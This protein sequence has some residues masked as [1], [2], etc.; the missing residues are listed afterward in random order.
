M[1]TNKYFVLFGVILTFAISFPLFASQDINYD[2][3]N[4]NKVIRQFI[5]EEYGGTL[6]ARQRMAN[7]SPSRKEY[8][9]AIT[10]PDYLTGLVISLDADPLVVV[11]KYEYK[12]ILRSN[13]DVIAVVCFE[14]IAKTTGK[15][16][17]GRKIVP[18]A[19][20]LKN[21]KYKLRK[22]NG[23]WLVVDPPLPRVSIKSIAD[24]YDGMVKTMSEVV[25]DAR[26]S[27]SQLEVYETLKRDK[28]VIVNISK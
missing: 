24:H 18:F 20:A 12:D 28:K 14:E 7:F 25:K 1:K 26:V 3:A 15:G 2:T 13:G 22:I 21:V 4:A 9:D 17:P 16:L 8:R 23:A 11:K 19:Q 27:K 10:H 5:E 6:D